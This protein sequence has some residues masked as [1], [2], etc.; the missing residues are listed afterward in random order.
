MSQVLDDLLNLL[1][2]ETIEEGLY[3]GQSQDLGFAAL[4]GGQVMGQAL[5]AAKETLPED[6]GVHSFHSYFLRPGDAHKPIVYDVENI[7]DG[8]S[9]STRRVQAIQYGKPIFYMTASFQGEEPGLE[10]QESMP[11]VPGPEGLISDLDVHREHAELIPEGLRSKFT[12]DKPILM[13]FVTQYNPFNPQVEE[14]KRYVWIKANGAMPDDHRIHKYLLAYASDFNFL[15][16]ALQPHGLSFAHPKMQMATIDHAMWFH[17]DFRMDDWLL[18][19]IDS[20]SASN[21]RGL[22]RGQVFNRAGKL[23][24][25]TIQEGLIR[26]R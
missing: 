3:R 7:R 16:T 11:D 1:E 20:P 13:R 19:A 25:S 21:A 12:S 10:H 2:L 6:R 14:P 18:Y 4:F 22:V 5:S 15:P 17:R 9:F 23:V 24:A 26:Q 8:K